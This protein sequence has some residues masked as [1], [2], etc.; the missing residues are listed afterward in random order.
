MAGQLQR[1]Q[2]QEAC[3][4]SIHR[5]AVRIDCYWVARLGGGRRKVMH[6]ILKLEGTFAGLWRA[7]VGQ[8]EAHDKL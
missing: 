4:K 5:T 2:E 7:A 6:W 3:R 8:D 1:M